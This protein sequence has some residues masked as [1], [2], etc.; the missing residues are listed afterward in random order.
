MK[1][2]EMLAMCAEMSSAGQGMIEAS[3]KNSSSKSLSS[4]MDMSTALTSLGYT[5]IY[6]YIYFGIYIYT[7]VHYGA[8]ST[9]PGSG[10]ILYSRLWLVWPDPAGSR[11]L[12][13]AS[14]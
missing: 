2:R 6:I 7:Y 11:H 1:D 8:T 3:A 9:Q 4:S 13:G 5:Y 12:I 14:C 10:R